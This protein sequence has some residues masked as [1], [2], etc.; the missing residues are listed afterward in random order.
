MFN[1]TIAILFGYISISL[2]ILNRWRYG[3]ITYSLGVG[4]KMNMLLYAPGVFL[5]LLLSVGV[6]ETFICLTICAMVQLIIGYPFLSTFPVEYI[7][8]AFEFNRVFMYKWTTNFKFL[9]EITFLNKKLSIILLLGTVITLLLFANKWIFDQRRY[10]NYDGDKKGEKT[11]NKV[12][13]LLGIGPLSPYFIVITIF[14]SNFVG[15]FIL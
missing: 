6:Y 7:S 10:I 11:S 2:F 3:C 14:T 12:K 8:R 4:V 5:C 9:N 1:D 13:K 15:K